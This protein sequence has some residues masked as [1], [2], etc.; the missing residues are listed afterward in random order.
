MTSRLAQRRLHAALDLEAHHLAEAA[1]A[2]L[3]LD[4]LE[5]VVG[6]VRD[7]VVG[8]ARDA[9]ERVVEDLHAREEACRGSPRSGRS[10]G[11]SVAPSADGE[12]PGDS[13]P[14][15]F[16]RAS[17]SVVLLGSRRRTARLSD[18]LRG[19][20]RVPGPDRERVTTGKSAARTTPP[21]RRALGVRLRYGRRSGCLSASSARCVLEQALR[22]VA[23]AI[24]C[25]WIA[26]ERSRSGSCRR[27]RAPPARLE[28]SS[29]F[30]T[31]TMKNSSRFD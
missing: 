2:E 24:T 23:W 1:P 4:R 13:S 15:T 14:G 30:A 25:S 28:L 22:A 26:G 8:V 29:R 11:T 18:R 17:T 12:E 27:R 10:S 6:L 20:E 5:Q 31:R 9:E 7:V 21:A 19:R 16:T 3:L